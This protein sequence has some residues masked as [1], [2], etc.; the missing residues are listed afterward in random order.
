VKKNVTSSTKPE[1]HNVSQRRQKRTEPRPQGTCI[2]CV[3]VVNSR[4][5]QTVVGGFSPI[6][7]TGRLRTGDG[8][9]KLWKIR[10]RTGGVC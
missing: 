7:G 9:V 2:K 6:S 10:V 5:V 1:V 4:I 8:S 3:Y